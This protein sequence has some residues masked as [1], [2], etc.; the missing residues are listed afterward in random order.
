[1]KFRLTFAMLV[2]ALLTA[3]GHTEPI[4]RY[5]YQSLLPPEA[6]LQ[7]CPVTAP[8]SRPSYLQQN[9][10]GREK[11][12]VDTNNAQYRNITQC[13]KDKT[14]LRDWRAKQ[15]QMIKEQEAKP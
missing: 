11:L 2:V 15:Q 6:L 1:M 5:K 8:P 4:V 14:E 9:L 7:D 3:C 12:L 10:S 13:N